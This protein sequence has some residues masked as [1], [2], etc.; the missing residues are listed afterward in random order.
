MLNVDELLD[1]LTKAKEQLG[2]KTKIMISM[3]PSGRTLGHID[4]AWATNDED[5]KTVLAL[6]TL[7]ARK[8]RLKAP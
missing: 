8:Y 1:V 3:S 2:G 6:Y 5:K 4:R 7:K